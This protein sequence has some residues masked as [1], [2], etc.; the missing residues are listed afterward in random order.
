MSSVSRVVSKKKV[1]SAVS[2]TYATGRRKESTARVWIWRASSP[3]LPNADGVVAD[4]KACSMIKFRRSGDKHG[5][6]KI[7]DQPIDKR[8]SSLEH[9]YTILRPFKVVNSSGMFECLITVRGGGVS[10]QASAISHGISRAL[11]ALSPEFRASLKKEGLLTRDS[12]EVESKKYG[13]HKARKSVQF[14][15]R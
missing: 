5:K 2:R 6:M 11:A 3:A 8:F 9:I 1:N 14:S 4:D 13:R 15:K 10:G 7:V 12:R